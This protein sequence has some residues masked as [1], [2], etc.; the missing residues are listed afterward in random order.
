[1]G[2]LATRRSAALPIAA[3]IGGMVAPAL[4]YLAFMAGTPLQHGWGVPIAT[5]TA[6]AIA[7]I[8]LLGDRVPVAL[9][10]FLRA[11]VIVAALIAIAVVA[12]FYSTEINF[13]FIALAVL[14]T[15]VMLVFNRCNFYQP[16]PYVVGGI[17]LWICVH[18]GGIHATLAGV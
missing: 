2:H 8:V 13:M 16:V 11:A 9:R 10:V 6:F 12:L 3:S 14:T 17:I 1:I 18:N 5:D 15:G 4:I 7:L